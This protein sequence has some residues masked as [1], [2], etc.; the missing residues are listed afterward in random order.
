MKVIQLQ[1]QPDTYLLQQEKTY[2]EYGVVTPLLFHHSEPARSFYFGHHDPEKH[3][4]VF[5]MENM[6]SSEFTQEQ[7]LGMIEATNPHMVILDRAGRETDIFSE[8]SYIEWVG[9]V[10]Q[11]KVAAWIEGEDIRQAV[12]L[13][14]VLVEK[15]CTKFAI[16]IDSAFLT[17]ISF[18]PNDQARKALSRIDFLGYLKSTGRWKPEHTF[19]LTGK[20]TTAEL[21]FYE[22]L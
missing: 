12:D 14:D 11:G 3:F 21:G 9:S 15:G 5:S 4:T 7:L 19:I 6:N 22:Y 20:T 8:S 13:F 16:S 1:N 18:N 2:Q 17:T 10:Q